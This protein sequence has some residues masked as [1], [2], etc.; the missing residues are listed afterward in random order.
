MLLLCIVQLC[1]HSF[2]HLNTGWYH[3][4]IKSKIKGSL[5]IN[6][7]NSIRYSEHIVELALW[8]P[9]H[10]PHIKS[11]IDGV[12]SPNVRINNHVEILS[13][14][15]TTPTWKIVSFDPTLPRSTLLY[16]AL[17]QNTPQ[18]RNG[19][20]NQEAFHTSRKMHFGF[21]GQLKKGRVIFKAD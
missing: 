18:G 3:Y 7:K 9:V 16:P 15:N 4:F 13:T 17:P 11:R 19:N 14:E 20:F 6:W 12:T 10:I 21:Y 2:D 5:K 8:S 1:V